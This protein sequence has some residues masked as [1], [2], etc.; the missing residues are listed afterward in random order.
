MN[1]EAPEYLVSLF[2]QGNDWASATIYKLYFDSLFYYNMGFVKSRHEAQ[3]IA[4]EAFLKLWE[5][6]ENFESLEKIGSFLYIAAKNGCLDYLRHE[7][8]K[9]SRK[10]E[11]IRLLS[12]EGDAF[13]YHEKIAAEFSKR[14]NAEVEKLPRKCRKI[15]RLHFN[16]GLTIGEIAYRLRIS[17]KTVS[18]QK[19]LALTKLRLFFLK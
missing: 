16:D 3:D 18:N 6:R 17:A 14:V 15:V 13:L 5:L 10:E 9:S 7:K 12:R 19:A 2:K 8:V 1:D 4:S 11:I